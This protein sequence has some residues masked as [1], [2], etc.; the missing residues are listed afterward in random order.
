MFQY[1]E[2]LWSLY[3]SAEHSIYASAEYGL[4]DSAE[5]SV[6]AGAEHSLCFG[7]LRFIFNFV[8]VFT[9]FISEVGFPK[10]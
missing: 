8:I 5:H 4:Y 9:V 10:L 1:L 2:I 7:Y 6:Y 3:A